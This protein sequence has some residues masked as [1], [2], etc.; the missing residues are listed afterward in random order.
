[1]TAIKTN[2]DDT[3][4]QST[5]VPSLESKRRG[6]V[7]AASF[8]VDLSFL[9]E[10]IAPISPRGSFESGGISSP[11]SQVGRNIGPDT[12]C[13]PNSG[14]CRS[15]TPMAKWPSRAHVSFCEARLA[16][17]N[18]TSRFGDS[19]G[20]LWQL[21]GLAKH[22]FPGEPRH[23]RRLRRVG[24]KKVGAF[25]AIGGPGSPAAATIQLAAEIR[26]FD[27]AAQMM[28]QVIGHSRSAKTIERLTRRVGAELAARGGAASERRQVIAI[29]VAVVSCDGGRIRTRAANA[30]PGVHEAA[31]RETKNSSFES[32]KAPAESSKDPCATLPDTFRRVAHV[33]QIA[34]K[35]AFS[36]VPSTPAWAPSAV[37]KGP[38]RILRTCVSSMACSQ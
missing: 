28:R 8:P 18:V 25:D 31:W 23:G 7:T 20:K 14:Q 11:G 27:R 30:G 24:A 15:S 19:R 36:G 3:V 26:S 29:D 21:D 1:V 16:V 12:R 38:N 34:E 13:H 17:K 4:S 10:S 2:G 35:A 22:S 6:R 32:M 5:C 9:P 33:A 37:Y